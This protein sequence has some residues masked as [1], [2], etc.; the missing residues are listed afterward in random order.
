[1][2]VAK[3]VAATIIA[4]FD[5][6]DTIVHGFFYDVMMYGLLFRGILRADGEEFEVEM[7]GVGLFRSNPFM[8]W[9]CLHLIF[10][11]RRHSG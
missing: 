7:K 11:S 1:M 10:L 3:R 9:T 8:K 6:N 5:A 4:G 2:L